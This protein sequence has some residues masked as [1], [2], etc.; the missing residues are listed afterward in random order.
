M[1][2][3]TSPTVVS[4][5]AVLTFLVQKS[6]MDALAARRFGKRFRGKI[7]PIF[8]YPFSYAPILDLG[9]LCLFEYCISLSLR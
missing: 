6:F 8:A 4:R 1:G 9:I 7:Q 5:I 2:Q 3:S